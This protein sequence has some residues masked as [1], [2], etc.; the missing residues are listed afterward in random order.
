MAVEAGREQGFRVARPAMPPWF[1]RVAAIV[2][3]IFA[4]IFPLLFKN[5]ADGWVD[6]MTLA[7]AYTVMALGLNVV[8]GFAGLLDLG[9]VAFFAIGAYCT[10]WFSSG[11][12]ADSNIHVLVSSFQDKLPGVHLNWLLVAIIAMVMCA[13]A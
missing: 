3:I 6:D 5:K 8:V 12:Y 11:F 10:G 13:V 4:F 2:V 9:Y 7:L 1:S